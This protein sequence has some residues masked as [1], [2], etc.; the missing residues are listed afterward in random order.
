MYSD[1]Y[2]PSDRVHF[3][4]SIENNIN[5]CLKFVVLITR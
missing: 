4:N 5:R 3:S 2:A 1:F